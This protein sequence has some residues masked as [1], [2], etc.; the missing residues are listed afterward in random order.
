MWL[1]YIS[2]SIQRMQQTD[3]VKKT[4]QMKMILKYLCTIMTN[5]EMEKKKCTMTKMKNKQKHTHSCII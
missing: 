2:F 4:K 5:N 1:T 3:N